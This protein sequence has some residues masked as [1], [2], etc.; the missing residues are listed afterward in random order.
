MAT[1][2]WPIEDA[3]VEDL[4]TLGHTGSQQKARCEEWIS[5]EEWQCRQVTKQ[6]DEYL[7]KLKAEGQKAEDLEIN[8]RAATTPR[9]RYGWRSD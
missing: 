7:A 5:Y 2:D 6:C 4:S 3:P 1:D 9:D 8:Q